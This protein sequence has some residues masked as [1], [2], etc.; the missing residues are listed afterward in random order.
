MEDRAE[1]E[2]EEDAIANRIRVPLLVF[3]V[4][5]LLV[6]GGTICILLLVLVVVVV[7]VVVVVNPVMAIGASKYNSNPIKRNII[8]VFAIIVV[9]FFYRSFLFAECRSVFS[10]WLYVL[11]P[12]FICF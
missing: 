2:D 3:A 5:P 11:L 1:E 10:C 9:L 8:G 12:L 7:V 6:G 4:L